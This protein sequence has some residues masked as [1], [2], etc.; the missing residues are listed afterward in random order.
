MCRTR[1]SMSGG[2]LRE[3]TRAYPISSHA[4]PPGLQHPA[5]KTTRL[6]LFKE[7]TIIKAGKKQALKNCNHFFGE[8]VLRVCVGQF[9]SV[10][11]V[12]AS[13]R[14]P[15]G[16]TSPAWDAACARARLSGQPGRARCRQTATRRSRSPTCCSAS[17]TGMGRPRCVFGEGKNGPRRLFLPLFVKQKKTNSC[18]EAGTWSNV[19]SYRR[20][21]QE[22][23]VCLEV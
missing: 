3:M 4:P 15:L 14:S 16:R 17:H 6:A 22:V 8:I 7:D 2:Q 10:R 11:S 13:N 21:A 9:I 5:P 20:V 23:T 18:R 19:A 12:R 1:L